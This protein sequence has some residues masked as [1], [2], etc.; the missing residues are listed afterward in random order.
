MIPA[1]SYATANCMRAD[2]HYN[3]DVLNNRT[4]AE[5][6]H[7]SYKPQIQRKFEHHM[8]NILIADDEKD[9]LRLI[10][11]SLEENGYTVLTAQNGQEAW[12]ILQSRPVDL[13]ILDVMMPKMDGFNLLRKI[14]EHSTIPV[15]FLTARA[16]DMDK[17]LGPG[18]GGRL[19]FQALFHRGTCCK[20][21]GAPSK[22]HRVSSGEKVHHALCTKSFR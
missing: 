17:V 10:Q 20:G 12:E 19:S 14:R 18:W 2:F 5:F 6:S 7:P 9:I 21:G 4:E 22:K 11:I 3:Y 16:D 1:A 15:I 13:A 8:K